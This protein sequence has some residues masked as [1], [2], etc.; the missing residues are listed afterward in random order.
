MARAVFRRHQSPVDQQDA[1]SE[2]THSCSFSSFSSHTTSHTSKQQ[3]PAQQTLCNTNLEAQSARKNVW[4]EEDL[5]AEAPAQYQIPSGFKVHHSTLASVEH[6][7]GSSV[8]DAAP[9]PP[10]PVVKESASL[11]A[12]RKRSRSSYAEP[13]CLP[14]RMFNGEWA[15]A[16]DSQQRAMINSSPL[17]WS[18][19]I[20]WFELRSCATGSEPVLHLRMQGCFRGDTEQWA[21]EA[22]LT[23]DFL[24][25]GRPWQVRVDRPGRAVSRVGGPGVWVVY[26]EPVIQDPHITITFNT[27]EPNSPNSVPTL[28]PPG[29][30]YG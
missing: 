15:F 21:Y 13:S 27:P 25:H 30:L 3:A 7:P 29:M 6:P 4:T 28:V 16:Q 17:H 20:D 18:L 2:T 9:A 12:P 10:E 8:E 19:I 14:D 11:Q 23:V 26:N 5:P 1:R 24:A 22:F